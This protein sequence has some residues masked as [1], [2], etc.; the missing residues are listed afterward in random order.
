MTF[1]VSTGGPDDGPA[2]LL[3]HGFPQTEVCFD[4][5]RQRL[6]EAGLRTIAPRQR[7]YSRGA[8]PQGIES[9][10]L[11]LLAED[12]AGI[13]DALDIRYAHIVGHGIGSLVAWQFAAQ[14]PLRAM[15]LVAVSFGHPSA[16]AEAMASD[17]DQRARSRYLDL[18]MQAGPAEK[19]LLD[20][21]A[22]TLLATAPGGGIET[23]STKP[24]LTA[25][26][27]W[28]RANLRPGGEGLD[29]PS[30]E[31]PTTMVWGERDAIAGRRQAQA[32]QRFVR[33]DFRL[34]EVPD[35]DHWVP[36]RAPAALASEVA[37]RSM[38]H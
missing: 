38:R 37:L 7:G 10:A 34:S 36:L 15:S 14:Y 27:N 22:R 29:C 33:A 21:N 28:Y 25:A 17:E 16:L 6:H 19:H 4:A 32:S 23:L 5:T 12:A 13:L 26:L 11:K 20:N 9:Y 2:V 30:V 35:V 18:F 24:A 1:E 8:R 3:L 31:V